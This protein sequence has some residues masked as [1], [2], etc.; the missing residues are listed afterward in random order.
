LSGK[1]ITPSTVIQPGR[2]STVAG[3]ALENPRRLLGRWPYQWLFPGPNSR[4]VLANAAEPLPASGVT[5]Q[6][7]SYQVPDG[8]RF[9][10]RALVFGFNGAGWTEGTPTGISFTLQVQA[11]GTRNVDFLAGVVT[12]LGSA[13]QPYPI[14]GRLEFAPLDVLVV[15]ATNL[16]GQVPAGPPNNVFAHLV[17]HTYPNE[18][19][20]G[21]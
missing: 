10:L 1:V 14:L 18:E 9:S 7:L 4:H 5:V 19:T 21:S 17:G 3:Q 2:S 6:V 20:I 8:L 11:A 12:H 16:G 13:T 15:L